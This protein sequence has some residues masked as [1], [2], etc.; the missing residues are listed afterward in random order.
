MMSCRVSTPMGSPSSVTTIA[1]FASVRSL[2][3]RSISSL[4][5]RAGNGRPITSVTGWCK[6]SALSK[7]D[8]ITPS[9]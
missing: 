4:C 7:T 1:G 6:M 5:S 2:Y 8:C 3:A 9:R